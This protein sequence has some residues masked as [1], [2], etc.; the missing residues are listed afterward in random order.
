MALGDDSPPLRAEEET[1][2]QGDQGLPREEHEPTSP[3]V[4]ASSSCQATDPL[5]SKL[6]YGGEFG[7]EVG[8]YMSRLQAPTQ[9]LWDWD[10]QGSVG[11][12]SRGERGGRQERL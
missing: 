11:S 4:E 6:K 8:P 9:T 2:A 1:E 12:L 7:A 3:D 5:W 10:F